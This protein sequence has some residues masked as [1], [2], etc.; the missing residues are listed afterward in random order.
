MDPHMEQAR[1]KG[2]PGV[3]SNPKGLSSIQMKRKK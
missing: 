3:I 2:L 1:G